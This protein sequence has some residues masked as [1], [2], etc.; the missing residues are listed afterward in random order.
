[1][2]HV[3]RL[4]PDHPRLLPG[5]RVLRRDA[6][7][8]Q[9]GVGARAVLLPE[10]P[11]VRRL[12]GLL[13]AATAPEATDVSLTGADPRSAVGVALARL[14]RAELLVD[15]AALD[16]ASPRP[17]PDPTLE[18]AVAAAWS[19]DPR[20][21]PQRWSARRLGGVRLDAPAADEATLRRLLGASGVP[22]SAEI[23]VG[24][25]LV[26]RD[27]EPVREELDDLQRDDVPHLVVRPDLDRVVLGPFV[28]PGRTACLRCLDAHA[29]DLDPRWPLLVEQLTRDAGPSPCDPTLWQVALGW[30]AHDVVRWSEGRQP[31]TWSTTVTLGPGVVPQTQLHRRHPRCGCGWGELG[32]EEPRRPSAHQ[33]SES[34]LPSIE[35]RFSREQVSQ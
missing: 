17:D 20:S 23:G 16:A 27:R 9:V 3:A 33:K 26:V 34:S 22:V 10:H 6:D 13:T 2:A 21:A 25:V 35:R 28:A 15:G 29:T 32:G 31:S 1:M 14:A 4:L 7:H 19:S 11:D 30:A 24:P 5:L 18:R 12:L 8:L